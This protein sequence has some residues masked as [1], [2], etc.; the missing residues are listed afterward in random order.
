MAYLGKVENKNSNIKRW[1]G[2]PVII[3]APTT[4]V[5]SYGDLGFVP[6]NEPSTFITINGIKQHDNAFSLTTNEITFTSDLAELDEVEVVCIIDVGIPL[7]TADNTIGIDQLQLTEGNADQVIKTDGAG[8]LSF[9][10]VQS[11]HARLNDITALTPTDDVFIVGNGTNFVAEDNATARSSLGLGTAAILNVGTGADQIV[12]RDGSGDISGIVIGTDVLA[13]DGDGSAL[14]GIS[15]GGSKTPILYSSTVNFTVPAGVTSVRAYAVGGGGNG[16]IP[17]SSNYYCT[18]G[19]GGG[20]AYGDIS[21]SQGDVLNLDITSKIAT[22]LKSGTTLLTGNPG[23]DAVSG[24]AGHAL[25]GT[26]VKDA[27]VTDGGAYS[28]GKGGSMNAT[29][30]P[31]G[32][33]AGSPLGVGCYSGKD[34]AGGIGATYWNSYSGGGAG[35]GSS[36]GG[37]DYVSGG[38]APNQKGRDNVEYPYFTDPLIAGCVAPGLRSNTNELSWW[39]SYPHYAPTGVG[40]EFDN[41]NGSAAST[42]RSHGNGGAFGGGGGSPNLTSSSDCFGG[43][44]GLLCGGGGSGAGS[45]TSHAGNGGYGGGGGGARQSNGGGTAGTGGGACII[46]IY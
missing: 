4:N 44:G 27:S 40:G 13:P 19:A 43:H 36:G 14:T 20:M 2:V 1:T 6:F 8:T 21:V 23:A 18:S 37:T 38:S 31:G 28:G 41:S 17:P 39:H 32:G 15:V 29:S 45:G 30:G 11:Q 9:V 42:A 46:L 34:G 16:A 12:Q 5:I 24:V 35:S 25:G 10:D 22:V 33:G 26:A 7:T 3:G